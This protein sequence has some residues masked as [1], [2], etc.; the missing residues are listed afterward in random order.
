MNELL[1]QRPAP[2]DAEDIDRADVELVQQPAGQPRQPAQP[3][4]K[5]RGR[6]AADTG[7]VEG[8]DPRPPE[9]LGEGRDGFQAGA[10]AVEDKQRPLGI[11]RPHHRN[12]QVLPGDLEGA[13]IGFPGHHAAART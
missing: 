6:R 9:P 10:D 8:H 11:G 2:G 13:D 3:V 5:L 7:D 1:R 12:A 4:G